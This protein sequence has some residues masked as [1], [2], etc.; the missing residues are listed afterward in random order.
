MT[1]QMSTV[2]R[3]IGTS[4]GPLMRIWTRLVRPTPLGRTDGSW[5]VSEGQLVLRSLVLQVWRDALVPTSWM[6]R[7]IAVPADRQTTSASIAKWSVAL[8]KHVKRQFI[9]YSKEEVRQVLQQR[10]ELERTTIVQ[11]FENLGDD[12]LRAAELMK[13]QQKRGRW[14]GGVNLTKYDAERFEF[15]RSQRERMGIV[16]TTV[17]PI[18]LAA[19]GF[20]PGGGG[21]D[22]GL[23]AADPNAAPEVYDMN[24]AAEGDDY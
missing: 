15:E 10:A 20:A 1:E 14:A 13:K 8:M 23:G 4:L 18:Q 5:T 16:E 21:E 11:E 7:D 3:R 22:Y 24:Q 19:P 9:K 17:E 12:D 6:Y 2:L